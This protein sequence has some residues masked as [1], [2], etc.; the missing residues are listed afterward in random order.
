MIE[1]NEIIV[2]PE[3]EKAEEPKKTFGTHNSLF[4]DATPEQRKEWQA[5]AAETR[6]RK[7]TDANGAKDSIR[8]LLSLA[9]SGKLDATMAEYG[10]VEEERTNLMAIILKQFAM[11][12][13]GNIKAFE[14]LMK[15]AGYEPG[16]ERRDEESK[17][18]I[19]AI[20]GGQAGAV[21]S[22]EDGNDVIIYLPEIESVESASVVESE[23]D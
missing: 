17:A 10:I 11:A 20:Q 6:R 19:T 2:V 16:E 18:R 4:R 15:Y 22:G 21:S 23:E 5:K 7:F 13:K 12:V 1:E 8:Y 14:N 3:E 9:P